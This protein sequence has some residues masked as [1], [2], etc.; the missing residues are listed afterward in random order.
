MARASKEAERLSRL[1]DLS[2]NSPD[3]GAPPGA[4]AAGWGL[5]SL[6]APFFTRS[7]ARGVLAAG[8]ASGRQVWAA[9]GKM[10]RERTVLRGAL[11]GWVAQEGRGWR[12][13]DQDQKD[14][15]VG[16]KVAGVLGAGTQGCQT[17]VPKDA[18]AGCWYPRMLLPKDAECW[19]PNAPTERCWYPTMLDDGTQE[20][21]EAGCWY[22]RM[23]WLRSGLLLLLL[24]LLPRGRMQ[25][26]R[27]L[28]L[29]LLLLLSL[30]QMCG[31]RCSE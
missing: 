3:P 17:L 16:S 19:Y 29:L 6:D 21:K 23:L 26:W 7:T 20:S 9:A 14:A 13:G 28:R 1:C 15:G 24:L 25:G 22:P 12:R 11:E 18:G 4:S 30:L 8:G 27:R 31:G 5:A 2:M 10:R